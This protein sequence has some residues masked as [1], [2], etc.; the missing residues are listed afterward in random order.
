MKQADDRR[1]TTDD[2]PNV[3]RQRN[4]RF[5]IPVRESCLAPNIGLEN[6]FEPRAPSYEQSKPAQAGLVVEA[7]LAPSDSEDD[8]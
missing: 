7:G 6:S 4:N 8:I 5:R 3:G 2:K 1:L